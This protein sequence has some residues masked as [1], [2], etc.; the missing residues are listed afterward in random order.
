MTGATFNDLEQRVPDGGKG[1]PVFTID[2]FSPS[3]DVVDAGYSVAEDRQ[4]VIIQ[5]QG[6]RSGPG[7]YRLHISYLGSAVDRILTVP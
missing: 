3:G 7:E 5:F 6:Y 1:K 2:L 4:G